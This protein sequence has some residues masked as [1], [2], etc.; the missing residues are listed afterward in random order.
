MRGR[1]A[2]ML[3]RD[4]SLIHAKSLQ[5][6]YRALM[7]RG[8]DQKDAQR[9][10]REDNNFGRLNKPAVR[11][12]TPYQLLKAAYRLKGYEGVWASLADSLLVLDEIHAYE[13]ARL[14]LL[15][16]FLSELVSRWDAKVC[17]MTA[18][19]P[20]WLR[21]TLT[22][23]LS[24]TEIAPDPLLFQQFA[25]HR[26]EIL[27]GNVLDRGVYELALREF[28]AGHSVLLA[29]NTVGT[30]QHLYESLRALVPAEA[31][32]L[33]HSRFAV[34]DRLEKESTLLR[35]LSPNDQ[36]SAPTIAVATQVVE[37]S[38]NLD[39]DT[40]ITEPAPLEALVQRFGRV[41]R[42]R[43]KGIVPVRITTKSLHDEK[44]YDPE[45]M[46]R[47]LS[48][49]RQ[50]QG[51]VLDEG[52]VSE[53]LDRIYEGELE[54]KWIEEIARNRREFRQ[55]CLDSLRAFETDDALEAHFDSLFQG[56]EVLP[57][58]NIDAYC[59]LKQQSVLEAAQLLVPISWHHVQRYSDRFVWN[60]QLNVR[61]ADFSY[62]RE[63]G[64]RVGG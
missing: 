40:I 43:R 56:A 29:A 34:G 8:Y 4:V 42:A 9:L 31:L 47:S 39:F 52:R 24:A 13:P 26:I 49:L 63:Y 53:W 17:A 12:S 2:E 19:M 22:E 5:A 36:H 55:S 11:V 38:L 54:R 28:E 51:S 30:A 3:S 48:I 18:T 58:S 33:L 1:L 7:D 44:V 61:T 14:G 20:S 45:L 15:F 57:I 37:V 32:L 59:C 23:V 50:N 16:E 62:D 64:L 46:A 60:Q 35:R 41:N 27:N 25:R 6:I 21:R 10:A